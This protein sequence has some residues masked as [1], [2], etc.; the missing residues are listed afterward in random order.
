MASASS[1]PTGTSTVPPAP[2]VCSIPSSERP[3]SIAWTVVGVRGSLTEA[4][5]MV[6][7]AP[8]RPERGAPMTSTPPRRSRSTSTVV[9]RCSA[10]RSASP[11]TR[12]PGRDGRSSADRSRCSGSGSSHGRRGAARPG[13]DAAAA[14]QRSTAASSSVGEAVAGSVG[15]VPG[16]ADVTAVVGP[17]C[18]W[19]TVTRWSGVAAPVVLATCRVDRRPGPRRSTARPGCSAGRWAASTP[20][21][22]SRLS[23]SS[24]TLRARRI[25]RLARMASVTTPPGRWVASSRWTPRLRPRWATSSSPSRRSGSSAARVANSST[26]TSSA[27][28]ASA[29]GTSTMSVTPADATTRSRRRTSA[30]NDT[31]ARRASAGPRS[32]TRPTTWGS[33]EIPRNAAPP[34]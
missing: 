15:P 29:A 22:T 21:M 4:A 18:R 13:S 10:G 6:R 12:A 32:V 17:G 8:E 2:A 9:R 20:S 31:S 7:R 3:L 1:A 5:A 19:C 30:R 23:S 34:L 27:G 25:D 26:T 14:R 28:D 33:S 11:I 16:R 24:A